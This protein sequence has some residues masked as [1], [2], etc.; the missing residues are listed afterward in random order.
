MSPLQIFRIFDYQQPNTGALGSRTANG[1]QQS[2]VTS[3]TNNAASADSFVERRK[4]PD[5]RGN[6]RREKQQA[7]FL[8][9]RKTQ[10]RRQTAGRRASDSEVKLDYKPI[11]LKG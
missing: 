9:T 8:N 1:I 4:T 10:G 5:R 11:S 7:T 6:D 2:K 3:A